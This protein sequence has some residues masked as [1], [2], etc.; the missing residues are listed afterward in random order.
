MYQRRFSPSAPWHRHHR[1]RLLIE[2]PDPALQVAEFR[3]YEEAGFDVALCAG[4]CEEEE[5]PL[6]AGRDCELVDAA[7]L[8]LMG[9]GMGDH[10]AEVAAAILRQRPALPIVAQVPRSAPDQ[11][12]IGCVAGYYPVSVEGQV[13]LLWKALDRE[14][15]AQATAAAPAPS[16]ARSSTMARLVDLLGW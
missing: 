5:C 15:P 13:R 1:P 2:D 12:P 9:P 6:T 3:L 16:T 8:V 11:C 14:R 7:D 10:R 4:P